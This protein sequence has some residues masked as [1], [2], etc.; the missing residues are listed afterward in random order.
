LRLHQHK[1]QFFRLVNTVYNLYQLGLAP[2]D[3]AE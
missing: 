3:R 2:N 1:A